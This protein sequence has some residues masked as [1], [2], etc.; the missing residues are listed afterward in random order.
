MFDAAPAKL[1]GD[2]GRPVFGIFGEAIPMLNLRR[3]DYRSVAPGPFRLLPKLARVAVKQWQYMGLVSE[4]M[5]IGAAVVDIGY[6]ANSF[7]YA[8]DRETGTMR[9]FEFTDPVKKHTRISESSI[10]GISEYRAHGSHILMDNNIRG[11]GRRVV[12]NI[13]ADL[14]ADYEIRENKFTPLCAVTQ[15]GLR[16]FH[17]THKAAGLPVSGKVQF[18]GRTIELDDGASAVLDWSAGC[19]ARYSYWNWASAAG[20]IGGKKRVG[21]NFVSGINEKGY[22]ENVYWVDGKPTKVDTMFFDYNRKDIL[23]PW[24]IRSND[25][26]VDLAFTPENER[27][28]NINLLLI[29]SRFHQPFGRFE[30]TLQIGR[31][32]AG[33]ELY[34]FVEEHEALW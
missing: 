11:G 19:P 26:K 21:I 33:V 15:N 31:K 16:G 14:Y 28:K 30:G 34:G 27:Y 5:I 20:M 29:K 18:Q 8:Y 10:K 12:I 23:G 3:F 6:V 4:R 22:T 13:S 9:E 1:I 32:K 2:E 17:Y 24:R 7:A 25:G